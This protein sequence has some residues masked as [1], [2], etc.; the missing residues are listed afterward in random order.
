MFKTL[1]VLATVAAL[2]GIYALAK[3]QGLTGS[4]LGKHDQKKRTERIAKLNLPCSSVNG[5]VLDVTGQIVAVQEADSPCTISLIY[6]NGD[7]PTGLSP[8]KNVIICGEFKKGLFVADNITITGG[9]PWTALDTSP[10][11]LGLVDHMI[12]F[13]AYWLL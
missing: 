9:T 13:I 10:Q 12:F 2:F 7:F 3:P 5:T 11:P 8:G 4:A 1:C 6:V